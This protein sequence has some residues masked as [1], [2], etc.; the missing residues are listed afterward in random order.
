VLAAREAGAASTAE[1]VS[2]WS[3]MAAM[4]TAI[5]ALVSLIVGTITK[6]DQLQEGFDKLSSWERLT[7]LIS[8]NRAG[9][10]VALVVI[11]AN[12]I[13]FAQGSKKWRNPTAPAKP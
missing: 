10:V 5:L 9:T 6:I 3:R 1:K 12:V 7:Q 4:T 2:M 13:V 8:E 11:G